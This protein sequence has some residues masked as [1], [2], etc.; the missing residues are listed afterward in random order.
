MPPVSRR[1]ANA[2]R[3]EHD[4]KGYFW[5]AFLWQ[6]MLAN[7]PFLALAPSWW[8]PPLR[9]PTR[10]GRAE[11]ATRG[12]NWAAN[13]KGLRAGCGHEIGRAH[14]ISSRANSCERFHV[15]AR[16]F[17]GLFKA[18]LAQQ[19]VHKPQD[20][21]PKHCFTKLQRQV[22]SGS[23]PPR[24]PTVSLHHALLALWP[25]KLRPT[26]ANHSTAAPAISR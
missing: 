9:Q 12:C 4:Y 1:P 6:I 5:C 14:R 25:G 19:A 16:Q 11:R 2:T 20:G 24:R 21:G 18:L 8:Q 23:A 15:P 26:S 3:N 17:H 22:A 7:P 10:N 13:K